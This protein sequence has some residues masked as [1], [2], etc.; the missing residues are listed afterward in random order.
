MQR[1]ITQDWLISY[2]SSSALPC[3]FIVQRNSLTNVLLTFFRT[4]LRLHFCFCIV[5]TLLL[6]WKNGGDKAFKLT[7]PPRSNTLRQCRGGEW[8]KCAGGGVTT[9][10]PMMVNRVLFCWNKSVFRRFPIPVQVKK[11][12]KKTLLFVYCV[13]IV[14]SVL[15]THCACVYCLLLHSLTLRLRYQSFS[16]LWSLFL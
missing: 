12:R 10:V 7:S 8:L 1:V 9:K 5:Y 11:K 15:F 13:H 3:I 2:Y 6:D 4:L 16:S 14:V